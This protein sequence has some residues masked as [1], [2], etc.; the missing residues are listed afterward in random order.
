MKRS[1][2]G[3]ELLKG[4]RHH[5][6]AGAGQGWF[7]FYLT[8]FIKSFSGSNINH[9][10]FKSGDPPL[11]EWRRKPQ[12]DRTRSEKHRVGKE[13]GSPGTAEL[14]MVRSSARLEWVA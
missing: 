9:D 1:N 3:I 12:E 4:H 6:A 11:P 2:S 8:A 10:T 13:G 14:L 7:P 5:P